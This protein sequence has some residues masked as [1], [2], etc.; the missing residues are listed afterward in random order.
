MR[1]LVHQFVFE[2]Y[3]R[4]ERLENSREA[5]ELLVTSALEY[6]DRV[7]RETADDPDLQSEIAKAYQRIGD[8]QGNPAAENL[9]NRVGALASYHKALKIR[10]AMANAD[11]GNSELQDL[12]NQTMQSINVLE[13]QDTAQAS[14]DGK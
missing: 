9:H 4:I 2:L 7:S 13:D 1:R 14:K 8:I 3:D 6:L 11:R 10:N 12:V 5:R